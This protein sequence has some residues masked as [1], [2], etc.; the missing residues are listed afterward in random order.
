MLERDV[1]CTD[2]QEYELSDDI[3]DL[4]T[5][6]KCKRHYNEKR[7]IEKQKLKSEGRKED[8][9]AVNRAISISLDILRT[10]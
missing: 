5:C 8:S 4:F 6:P 1:E 7:N 10:G 3:H 2:N 9:S